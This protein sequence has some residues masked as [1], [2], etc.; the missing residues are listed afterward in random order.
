MFHVHKIMFSMTSS[1]RPHEWY[2]SRPGPKY[3]RAPAVCI[4]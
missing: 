2:G 3:M 1:C 4:Y